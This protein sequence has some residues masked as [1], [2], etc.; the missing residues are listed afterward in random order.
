MN[1]VWV[2]FPWKW[3]GQASLF[4][5]VIDMSHVIAETN[6]RETDQKIGYAVANQIDFFRIHSFTHVKS[7][8]HMY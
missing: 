7:V 4:R 8:K 3:P 2:G 5:I 6:M 1:E